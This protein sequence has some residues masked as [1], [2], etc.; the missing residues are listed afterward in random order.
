MS[1][2]DAGDVVRYAIVGA[3]ASVFDMHR[4]AL[5]APGR[6]VVGACDVRA[7]VGQRRAA[8]LSCPFFADHRS[9]LAATHPDVAVILTPHPL[10]APIAIDCLEAGCHV[11]VEKPMAAAVGE[12]DAMIDAS[13]RT[14]RLLAVVFQ[15]R[16]RPEVRAAHALLRAGRLGALQRAQ[17]TATWTRTAAYY[18]AAGWRAT[19]SGEGG[20][21]LLNQAPHNLDLLCHLAGMPRRVAAWT[22]TRL[23]RIQTEDTVQAMLEWP[24]GALGSVHSSTAEAGEPDLIDIGGTAGS[25]RILPGALS[26]H[27]LD[28]DLRQFIPASPDP[29]AAPAQRDV[30]VPLEP[31]AGDDAAVY[32]QLEAA[33]RHPGT[34]LTDG[35]E[36]RMS[37]EL[38]NAMIYSSRTQREVELPLDRAQYAALLDELR[39]H[40]PSG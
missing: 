8:A 7:E 15:Q 28:A 35:V 10:H 38:A 5:S 25:L 34:P 4:P 16:H 33:I 1:G 9:M 19:W 31:G 26:Y 37:L 24:D 11:L 13:R 32:R 27:Q 20:G 22:R 17:V 14:N 12:A 3:G 30:P 2:R 6:A 18:A 36:G 40:P 23:H 29:F 39:A 21:V